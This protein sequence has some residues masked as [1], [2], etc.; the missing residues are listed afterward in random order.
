MAHTSPKAKNIVYIIPYVSKRLK[1]L[2]GITLR[3]FS[4]QLE[5][6]SLLLYKNGQGEFTV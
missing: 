3:S 6:I 4:Y 5:S 2:R 1:V